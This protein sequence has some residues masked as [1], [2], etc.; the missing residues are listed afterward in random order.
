LAVLALAPLAG[1][2]QQAPR[3]EHDGWER[4]Y[5]GTLPA[6]ARLRINGHGPV[7][8][9]AG[10]APSLAYTV[11]LSVRANSE[12]EARRILDR[13]ALAIVTQGDTLVLTAPG[14]V[15]MARVM[16]KAPR[17]TAVAVGTSDGTVEATGID[18]T[19]E[20]NSRAGAILT[21]RIHGRCALVTGGGDIR[22]GTV[23]GPVEST[24]NGGNIT[25]KL[26]HG[27]ARLQTYGGDITADQVDGSVYAQTAGGGVHVGKAGGWVNAAT[28][29]GEI[30]IEKAGGT[31]TARNM[32]GP[33]EVG[34]AAGVHCESA[35]GGVR[36][37]RISG[38]MRVSTS[39]GSILADL[40]GAHLVDSFLATAS[41]DITVLIPSK[42][43]VTIRAENAMADSM[44]RIVSDFPAIAAR[45]QGSRLIA[46]GALNGG[47][48]L[49]QISDTGGTI[50]IRKQ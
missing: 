28:G 4:T 38:P 27:D 9:N 23:D 13:A 29:G 39:M 19:L 36:L 47:G 41:G 10:A 45:R 5:A 25:L 17:L 16:V 46:Q 2:G 11:R 1:V 7:T 24:T 12:A 15:V 50:F 42:L 18:G 34:A 20:V 31:V 35:S 8:V 30:V 37:S 43:G 26:A 49:L 44:R 40:M 22:V 6:A 14:G 33:V 48:P 21:D 3:H 32:A